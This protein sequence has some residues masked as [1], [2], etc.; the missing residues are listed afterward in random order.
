[1]T[2][3]YK[4]V[5]VRKPDGAIVTVK[6]KLSPGEATAAP[7]PVQDSTTCTTVSS[8]AVETR[9][10]KIVTVRKDDG[11]LVK[12]RRL[13]DK[14]SEDAEKKQ[15]AGK[16]ADSRD[17]KSTNTATEMK[18][19]TDKPNPTTKTGTPATKGTEGAKVA[20]VVGPGA[21]SVAD[22][23]KF[24]DGSPNGKPNERELADALAE[25]AI[26]NKGRR[27]HRFKSSLLSGFGMAL[28][29]ALPSLELSHNFEDGDEI[30]SDDDDDY[31]VDDD[32]HGRGSGADDD[33]D[34]GH[35]MS[36][37]LQARHAVDDGTG[38][39]VENSGM[40]P[41]SSDS[42]DSDLTCN[43][44][45]NTC[46]L[47]RWGGRGWTCGCCGCQ[48]SSTTASASPCRSSWSPRPPERRYIE[49]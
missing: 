21:V 24:V 4:L 1:V 8:P 48:R 44:F 22:K 34:V 10:F 16:D 31:S 30:L 46:H 15:T 29:A 37:D 9:Q 14:Q 18:S 32:D 40:F 25:Q 35:D 23:P 47:R 13:V 2:T 38:R 49:S 39:E 45:R 27:S 6:R 41:W 20:N 5:K 3:G 12:V 17:L 7:A 19:T 43:S 11:T 42:L 26:Y 36:D 28:G 33:H